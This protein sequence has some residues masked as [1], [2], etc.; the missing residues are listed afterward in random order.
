M[1][2]IDKNFS[3]VVKNI[4]PNILQY[5]K[6]YFE[7]NLL[8]LYE[9]KL[10]MTIIIDAQAILSDAY[11]YV[12]NNKSFLLALM[13]SPFLKICAPLWLQDELEKKIP[14]FSE[15]MKIDKDKFRGAVLLLKEKINF[16][17][18]ENERSY[19]L[20][21]SK[22][23]QRDEKDVP[24]VALFFSIK[25]HGILT[26]DKHILETPEIKTWERPGIIGEVISVFEK[27]VFSFF[28][29]G[30]GLPLVFRFLYEIG[31]LILRSVWEVIKTIGI[32]IYTLVKEGIT[33]ISK[34]PDL[35][36]LLLLIF[37][38]MLLFYDKTRASIIKI[39]D[40][41]IQ[42][43][44]GMLRWFY[45]GFKNI[46]GLLASLI[47]IGLATLAFLFSKIEETIS[48]YQKIDLQSDQK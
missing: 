23:G 2:D 20:A 34:F 40:S 30:K 48:M 32:M 12:K 1:I 10:E 15:K 41:I 42:G 44:M 24:Y 17:S 8:Y 7:K 25:S 36:K 39:L 11:S 5:C 13:Q 47:E 27:G 26:K 31:A 29:V 9:N 21:K 45:D 6:K 38:I 43:I 37:G 4:D 16:V 46:L 14:E 28:L 33:A 18:L 19:N 22:I 3:E 35:I